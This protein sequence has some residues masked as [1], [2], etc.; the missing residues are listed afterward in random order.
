MVRRSGSL[1]TKTRI[2]YSED[3]LWERATGMVK[4]QWEALIAPQ[5]NVVVGTPKVMKKPKPPRPPPLQKK[6]FR[7][8]KLFRKKLPTAEKK[9][10]QIRRLKITKSKIVKPSAIEQDEKEID[11]IDLTGDDRVERIIQ[12]KPPKKN[13]KKLQEGILS[14]NLISKKRKHMLFINPGDEK[15]YLAGMAVLNGTELPPWAIYF[16]DN[17]TVKNNVLHWREEGARDLPFAGAQK[18]RDLVKNMYFD[19]RQPATIA[20][21]TF[22]LRESHANVTKQDVTRILRSF[23]TYQLN[24]ARRRPPDIKNR[25]FLY[26]PGMIAMDMFFPS[27]KDGWEKYNCLCCLDSWSRYVGLYAIETKKYKDVLVAMKDFLKKFAALGH[28]P[29]RILSD[30]G[31]DMAA[32]T[33]AIERYRQQKDGNKPLVM[34]TATGTPVLIVEGMNAQVQRRMAVFRTSGLIDSPAQ[35]LHEIAVQINNEPR[36]ARGGLTPLQLLSLDQTGREEINKK[37]R[38]RYVPIAELHGLP[39]I[40]VNDQVRLLKMTRKEQEQNKMKGFSAKWS[41]EI[42]TVFKKTKLRKNAFM[43]RY[44]IGLPDSYYRHELLKI[45]GG[46][47]DT[48]VP[49]NL[50][51]YKEVSIGSEYKP[52]DE[53]WDHI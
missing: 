3:S 19:P 27:R 26:N 53:E 46:V 40:N 39:N 9:I 20:P 43:F 36:Q 16:Y 49:Q 48:V 11:F 50:V 17:L 8:K 45:R 29:R 28:M 33:K 47:V 51:R 52:G 42:Y 13:Q 22:K 24:F 41:K 14:K 21:I 1:R 2:N 30:K 25:M 31:S 35:I 4:E 32:A 18:K 12:K 38:E 5:N 6:L 7:T 37:Y 44:H 15:I 34:H 10:K 23:E